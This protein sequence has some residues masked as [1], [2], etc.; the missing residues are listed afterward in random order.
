[1]LMRKESSKK[2]DIFNLMENLLVY[3]ILIEMS[4]FQMSNNKIGF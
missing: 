1:M 4:Y 3:V 2:T